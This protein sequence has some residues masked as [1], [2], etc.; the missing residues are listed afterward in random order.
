[1]RVCVSVVGEG[2][3]PEESGGNRHVGLGDNMTDCLYK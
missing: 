2:A 1:V 3:D